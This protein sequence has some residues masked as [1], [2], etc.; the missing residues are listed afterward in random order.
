MS[1]WGIFDLPDGEVHIAP[2]GPDGYMLPPHKAEIECVCEPNRDV[3]KNSGQVVW[4]HVDRKRG[5]H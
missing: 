3:V 5:A 2:V 1:K 4:V